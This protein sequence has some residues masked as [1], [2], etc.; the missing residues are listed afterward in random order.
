MA[1]SDFQPRALPDWLAHL[2]PQQ[3]PINAAVRA[4]T[5]ELFT[6]GASAGELAKQLERDPA[7]VL[8]LF[9]EANRALARYDREAHTLEHAVGLLGAGR[10]QQLFEQAPALD[11]EHPFATSYRQVLL[12]SQHAAA[13]ARLWAEGTGLWPAEEVFWSTLLAAS[14]LW[15]MALEAG[16]ALRT[17]EQTRARQG[18]LANRQV[19]AQLGCD[20]HALS[21][22]LAERWLLPQM[23]RLSWQTKAI[24]DRRQWVQLAR[25]ARLEEPPVIS[26]RELGELC[27]HPALV[28]ALANA[29][30]AEADWDWQSHR[31][32]RLLNA[33]AAACRRPLA[34]IISYCHKT[35]A[36][37][38][39]AYADTNLPTPG[40]KLLGYWNQTYCWVAAPIKKSKTP[41]AQRSTVDQDAAAPTAKTAHAGD[42]LIAAVVQRLRAPAQINGAREALELGVKALHKGIGFQRV[43][44]FFVRPQ[45]RELQTILSAGA[46]QSPALQQFRFPS[47][48]SQLLTQLLTKPICLLIDAQN[49]SKYW[50]HFPDSLRVAINCDNFVLMPVFAGERPIALMY[51]DNGSATIANGQRQHLLF[52]Q[53]CQQLTQCLGKLK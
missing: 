41:T 29:L 8:L 16:P 51:A 49:R 26:G 4:A 44:V 20:P 7:L 12:R 46:E 3:P 30:A 27:H 1:V 52:K 33:A 22:E 42:R 24:G 19:I 15:L 48:D 25:A 2:G 28:V 11:M 17:L 5:L 34:T 21:T 31:T 13:Q 23:S 53:L 39:R 37:V 40:A 50:P 6:A 18:A 38:S 43:A 9:R 32:L 47:Q 35:A 10:V 14:P 45:N 36:E